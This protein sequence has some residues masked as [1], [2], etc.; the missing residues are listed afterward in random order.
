[1]K[2]ER[3][4][5]RKTQP[6]SNASLPLHLLGPTRRIAIPSNHLLI[7]LAG[8]HYLTSGF[9]ALQL[10]ISATLD[11][12]GAWYWTSRVRY[13]LPGGVFAPGNYRAN[14]GG[15]MSLRER[16]VARIEILSSLG[17]MIGLA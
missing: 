4:P 17:S 16:K 12:A 2:G 15:F 13:A 11:V 3:A 14:I 7:E 10:L 1:L 6:C 9:L 8:R 5:S